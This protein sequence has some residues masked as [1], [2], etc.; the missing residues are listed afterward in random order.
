MYNQIDDQYR[1]TYNNFR[2]GSPY[3]VSYNSNNYIQY[4]ASNT[5]YK[6]KE[7]T[8]IPRFKLLKCPICFEFIWDRP[9]NCNFCNQYVCQ[10]CLD[11]MLANSIN[12]NEV[13]NCPFCRNLINDREEET[14]EELF[15]TYPQNTQRS[16][17]N[18]F[19]NVILFIILILIFGYLI[20]GTN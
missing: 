2:K 11:R 14:I 7:D 20:F 13:L 16:N 10:M 5:I 19:L 18:Y 12:N 9:I 15:I 6:S 4:Q 1:A 17:S 8:D 3:N